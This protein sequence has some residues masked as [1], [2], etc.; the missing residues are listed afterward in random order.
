MRRGT[1]LNHL[2]II[3]GTLR[4]CEG[5]VMVVSLGSVCPKWE[6]A[7]VIWHF[8]RSLKRKRKGVL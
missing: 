1:R 3:A 4:L 8:N 5:L 2:A 6:L 7:Y